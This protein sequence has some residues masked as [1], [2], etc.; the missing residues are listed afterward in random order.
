MKLDK[1][2]Y[3]QDGNVDITEKGWL[4]LFEF[5][6]SIIYKQYSGKFTGDVLEDLVSMSL[7]AC[8]DKLSEYDESRNSELG[9]YLYWI[10]RGE[11]TKYIQK[12]SREIAVDMTSRTLEWVGDSDEYC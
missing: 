10:V 11:V 4:D 9:G 7:L 3:F 12:M 6:K 2:Q 5:C 1:S 8:V